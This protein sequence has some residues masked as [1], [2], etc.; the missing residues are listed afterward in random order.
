[1]LLNDNFS[2]IY[3]IGQKYLKI[4]FGKLTKEKQNDIFLKFSFFLVTRLN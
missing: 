4:L 1:M 3:E 2:K